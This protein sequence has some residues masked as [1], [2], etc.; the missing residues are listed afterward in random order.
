MQ[1]LRIEKLPIGAVKDGPPIRMED[2]GGAV[3]QDYRL[4]D[5]LYEHVTKSN[6]DVRVYAVVDV[7]S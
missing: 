6:G 3:V 1:L 2:H 5:Y 7:S 4:G